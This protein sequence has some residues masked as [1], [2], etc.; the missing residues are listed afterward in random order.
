MYDV[1]VT[2]YSVT[3]KEGR[4]MNPFFTAEIASLHHRDLIDERQPRRHR[5]GRRSTL[6]RNPSE[7][8]SSI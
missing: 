2:S 6:R 4:Q 1:I 5:P 8:R 7:P 3:T